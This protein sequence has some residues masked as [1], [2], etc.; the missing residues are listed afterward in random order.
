MAT[1]VHLTDERYVH[2]IQ[3]TGLHLPPTSPKYPETEVSKYGIFAM[4]V[5]E[6]FVITHQWLRELKRR[7]FRT[8]V[9]IY[10]KIPD[11][12]LVW[13]GRYNQPKT[14]L[15]AAETVAMLRRNNIL[16]FEVIIPRSI[17]ATEIKIIRH[18]PQ[19]I[20]WRYYPEAKGKQI[21]CGCEYCQRGNIKSRRIR[22]NYKNIN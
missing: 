21:F 9:G 3:K 17:Q 8:A 20:G 15:T 12:E 11:G 14:Q 10:F 1:F 4:P 13:A 5:V 16:G 6:N 22:E 2:S 18:L 19:T 7:G